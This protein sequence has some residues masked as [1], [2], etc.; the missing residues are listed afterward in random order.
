MSVDRSEQAELV[1]RAR[2]GDGTAFAALVEPAKSRVW[3]V[4]LR[5]TGQAPDAEDA[6]QDALTS[7]WQNLDKFRE[8]AQ[9]STWL[10]RIASNAALSLIRKRRDQPTDLQENA[11]ISPDPTDA[12]DTT[13]R[14][15]R[16]L[17]AIPENFR[18]ILVLREYGELSYN[19][20]ADSLGVNVQTVKSRLNRARA[21]VAAQLMDDSPV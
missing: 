4:C 12:I 5:I 15:Q 17:A 2:A 16:A 14:V 7:A 11:W 3:S 6:M 8:D 13:D 21:A 9:F 18:A 1:A 20:I 19:E 10:Y